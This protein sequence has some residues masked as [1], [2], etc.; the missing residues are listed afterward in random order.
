MNGLACR[1]TDGLTTITIFSGYSSTEVENCSVS[2]DC[3]HF[4][5]FS[6]GWT[7]WTRWPW[8]LGEIWASLASLH[9]ICITSASFGGICASFGD[10]RQIWATRWWCR[11]ESW[12]YRHQEWLWYLLS[13]SLTV[14]WNGIPDRSGWRVIAT[15]WWW[16][17]IASWTYRRQEWQANLGESMVM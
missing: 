11:I 17:R 4:S 2:R 9:H 15:T 13:F 14:I 6:T 10:S 7:G 16:C 5:N 1:K 12:T 8:S 3:L